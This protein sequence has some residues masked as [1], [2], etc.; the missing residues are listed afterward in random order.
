[1]RFFSNLPDS[2]HTPYPVIAAEPHIKTV[3]SSLRPSDYM[4]WTAISIAFPS[5][6]YAL[7]RYR[8]STHPRN[9]GKVMMVQVP[10]YFTCGFLFACQNV[11]LRY[12]GWKENGREVE[13]W[14]EGAV[15]KQGWADNLW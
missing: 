6:F 4:A 7:E 15:R 14:T 8:P 3:V 9:L 12:W 10:F 5:A 11:Y 1:M 2:D 13:G